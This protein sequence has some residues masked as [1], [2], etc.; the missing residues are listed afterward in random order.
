MRSLNRGTADVRGR[1][2]DFFRSR[3]RVEAIGLAARPPLAVGT[4]DGGPLGKQ[5]DIACFILGQSP[6]ARSRTA[7]RF[8]LDEGGFT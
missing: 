7:V 5:P 2:Q 3:S 4:P 1:I 6:R 8:V